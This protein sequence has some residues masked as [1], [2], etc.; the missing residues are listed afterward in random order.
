MT[1][2]LDVRFA[3]RLLL[4][5]RWFTLAATI[6]LALGIGVNNTV[7][8][9]VNAVLIRA[10]P[11]DEPERIV[12]LGTRDARDRDG[13]ASFKE[14]E[15][16]RRGTQ[17]FTGLA[18]FVNTVWNLSDSDHLPERYNGPFITANAFRLIGARP[19]LGRG[20]SD[21]D[22]RP[23]APPVVIL[24]NGVWKTD[25]GD[26]SIIGRTI[27]ASEVPS[28]VIGVMPPGFKF[29]SNADVWSRWRSC[30]AS[31][32]PRST[33]YTQVFGRLA[34][35]VTIAQARADV[36]RRRGDTRARLSGLQQEHASDAH[37]VQ[38][39]RHR[40]KYSAL[41]PRSW[42][43]SHL[44]SLSPARTS[45]T[46]Y[47]P[48]GAARTR[49][50]IRLSSAL[51]AVASSSNCSSRV[52]YS[53]ASAACSD[54]ACPLSAFAC[55]RLRLRASG[56]RIGSSSPWTRA[57]SSS[58]RWLC[59]GTGFLFGLA[60]ALHVSKTDVNEALKDGG[61]SGGGAPVRADG[62]AR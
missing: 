51:L 14:Y 8:T 60:P 41:V 32:V 55:L 13:G 16:W 43:P 53:R 30:Q 23:G 22:D 6:A 45:P 18:A 10:L 48:L 21:E 46:C 57:C 52:S 17:S 49:I 4:K 9:L 7:F 56:C 5:D 25:G 1:L 59:L 3:V 47:S 19:I 11:F 37:A 29:P 2:W 39:A 50:S 44:C 20:F 12:A 40:R 54:S 58:C 27:K 24:G 61:R 62:P 36:E 34:P 35:G 15:D 38:R 42:A 33:R 31:P 28:T 26:P